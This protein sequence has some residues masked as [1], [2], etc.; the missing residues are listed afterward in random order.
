ML[1]YHET[2]SLGRDGYYFPLKGFHRRISAGRSFRALGS[3]SRPVVS[4][5]LQSRECM[6][7]ILDTLSSSPSSCIWGDALA[8]AM[9]VQGPA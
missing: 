7:V 5:D 1:K 8:Y 3:C 6:R 4:F 2:E 9:Y